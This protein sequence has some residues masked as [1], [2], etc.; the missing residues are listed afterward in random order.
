[1]FWNFIL[2][3]LRVEIYINRDSFL[4]VGIFTVVL[5]AETLIVPTALYQIEP[6]LQVLSASRFSLLVHTYNQ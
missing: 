5:L 1:M 4:G 2:L 6:Y 3:N